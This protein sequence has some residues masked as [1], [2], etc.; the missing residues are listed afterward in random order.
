MIVTPASPSHFVITA[1]TTAENFLL[2]QFVLAWRD[3]V[4]SISM[5]ATL[6]EGRVRLEVSNKL[7]R[8]L[9]VGETLQDKVKRYFP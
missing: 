7:P 1:E 8:A 4:A 5:G 3:G 6:P 2:K 9:P